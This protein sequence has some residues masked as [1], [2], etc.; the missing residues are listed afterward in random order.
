MRDIQQLFC[1]KISLIQ[2]LSLDFNFRACSATSSDLITVAVM[3][4][5]TDGVFVGEVF[6]AVFEQ[7][8]DLKRHFE[9]EDKDI[10]NLK[11][12]MKKDIGKVLESLGKSDK[13]EL[14]QALS[15]LR[16]EATKLQYKCYQTHSLK[17]RKKSDSI[18][19]E[20]L[21]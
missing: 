7:L 9:L 15:D 3:F 5:Y 20:F 2:E 12:N 4:E 18:E 13:N 14:Y 8:L 11:D 1:D 16:F 17:R 10:N 19:A 21:G 6:E